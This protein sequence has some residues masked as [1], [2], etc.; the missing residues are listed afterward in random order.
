MPPCRLC[1]WTA[2][3]DDVALGSPTGRYICLRCFHYFAES[4]RKTPDK[5]RRD[6]EATLQEMED[7]PAASADK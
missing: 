3:L 7:Q 2:E 5:L 4:M 1:N 6:V